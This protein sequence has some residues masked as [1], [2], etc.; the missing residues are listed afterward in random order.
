MKESGDAVERTEDDIHIAAAIR[1]VEVGATSGVHLDALHAID[2]DGAE[3][4][5]KSAG[6]LLSDAIDTDLG[7]ESGDGDAVGREVDERRAHKGVDGRIVSLERQRADVE[8]ESSLAVAHGAPLGRHHH[9]VQLLCGRAEGDVAQ[10]DGARD[11]HFLLVKDFAKRQD[12]QSVV[13]RRRDAQDGRARAVGEGK[14]SGIGGP[15]RFKSAHQV[16][17]RRAVRIQHPQPD[18]VKLRGGEQRKE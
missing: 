13:P 1:G 12:R 3:V 9:L 5:V 2:R 4:S 8:N 7:A 18:V 15:G 14:R 11:V 16:G 6:A 17:R 10:I